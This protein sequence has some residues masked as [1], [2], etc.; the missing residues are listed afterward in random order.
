LLKSLTLAKAH[1]RET[2]IYETLERTY[3]YC[4]QYL[5][6][7][8]Y[9]DMGGPSFYPVRIRMQGSVGSAGETSALTRLAVIELS[10]HIFHQS[11]FSL[12]Y[13]AL[14]LSS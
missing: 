3:K 1:A 4:Q 6:A 11:F 14:D 2:P 7:K 8:V 13:I 9:P 5:L 12:E 10:S